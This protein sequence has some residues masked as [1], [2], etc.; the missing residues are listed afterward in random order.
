MH[1]I[2]TFL[3]VTLM[4]LPACVDPAGPGNVVRTGDG[5]V[6]RASTDILESFPIQLRTHV[7]I[8]NGGVR[9]VTVE[10]PD[11]C[12]VL[13]RA[14]A[15]GA[16]RPAWDQAAVVGCTD[17]IV[18]VTL[19]PGEMTRYTSATGAREILGDSLADGEYR[20]RAYLRPRAGVVQLDAGSA[21]LSVPRR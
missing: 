18:Q 8:R 5:L 9:P 21:P 4:A 10:F 12:V 7:E 2:R 15:E 14:Y 1:P 17:A 3:A 16:S 19:G 6:Y 13:V 20:L 11:G